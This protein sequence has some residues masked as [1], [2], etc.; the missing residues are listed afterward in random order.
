[1]QARDGEG[2]GALLADDLVVEWPVGGERIA[3]RANFVGVNAEFPEGWSV[4]VLRIVAD[5]ETVERLW[6]AVPGPPAVRG[7]PPRGGGGASRTRPR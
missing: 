3:G 1:M 6:R 5:G 4:R 7:G 2:L